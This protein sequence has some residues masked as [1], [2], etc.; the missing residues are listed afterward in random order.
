MNPFSYLSKT[1]PN[2]ALATY[3]STLEEALQDCDSVLDVG[4]GNNSPL[5][6]ISA[7]KASVGVDGYKPAIQAS[8]KAKIHAKYEVLDIRDIV[9]KFG[10]KKFDAVIALDVI[11]HLEKKES[12]KL[13]KAMEAVAIKKVILLTP[14]GFFEQ[15]DSVNGLQ[16]HLCGWTTEELSKKGY[17]VSG[18]Y[19][20]KRLRGKTANLLGPKIITGVF[21]ELTHYLYTKRNPKSSFSLFAVKEV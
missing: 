21:S 14:N 6:L 16:E 4:C 20:W 3:G 2:F 19:G 11:E 8:K 5:R 12:I 17:K 1:F 7:K 15:F 13:L 9:K 10:K 18:M